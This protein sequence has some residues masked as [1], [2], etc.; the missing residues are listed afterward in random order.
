MASMGHRDVV[1]ADPAIELP[2]A[3]C[4]LGLHCLYTFPLFEDTARL[5]SS[6]SATTTLRFESFTIRGLVSSTSAH[7]RGLNAGWCQSNVVR[8]L[9]WDRDC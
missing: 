9:Q 5:G 7:D 4:L 6:A 1:G 8:V 3:F 2:N